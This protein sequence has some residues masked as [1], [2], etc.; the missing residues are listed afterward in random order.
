MKIALATWRNQISPVFDATR[1]VLVAEIENGKVIGK[2]YKTLGPELPYTQ[3]ARLSGLEVSVLICGAISIE[4]ASAIEMYGIQIIP[5]I[6]GE[7]NQ[8]LDA[9]QKGMLL[10]PSFQM[11]GCGMKHRKRFRGGHG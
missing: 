7:V 10:M 5:F 11:P 8:V 2:S 3:A 4:F 9:Y 6:T 1:M